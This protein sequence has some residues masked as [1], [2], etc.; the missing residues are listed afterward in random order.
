MATNCKICGEEIPAERLE[1]LPDTDTCVKCST[2]VQKHDP[3]LVCAKASAGGRNGFA[4][5]D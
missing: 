3:N 5:S 1:A 4:S 2:P